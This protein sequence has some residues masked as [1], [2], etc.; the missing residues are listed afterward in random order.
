M[1]LRVG[2]SHNRSCKEELKI[3]DTYLIHGRERDMGN[4]ESML[5]SCQLV[6]YCH[7]ATMHNVTR[8]LIG[9]RV[10]FEGL[11][12]SVQQRCFSG[13]SAC[14]KIADASHRSLGAQSWCQGPS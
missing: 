10:C 3:R 6:S 12:V 2:G 9:F 1:L 5:E 8:P 13:I 4:L 14:I 7:I 11:D